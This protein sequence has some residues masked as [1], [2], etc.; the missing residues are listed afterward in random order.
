[1]E[2][3]AVAIGSSISTTGQMLVRCNKPYV[4]KVDDV[5]WSPISHQGDADV[6]VLTTS[7]L[8]E[9][10]VDDER[11]FFFRN[12]ITP[13]F[14][15]R[16]VLARYYQGEEM[17]EETRL[18]SPYVQSQFPS[19]EVDQVVLRVQL[20]TG[21]SLTGLEVIT[22][23]GNGVITEGSSEW[24]TVTISNVSSTEYLQVSVGGTLLA[25]ILPFEG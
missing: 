8:V 11:V 17:L 10:V 23:Q 2:G 6:F 19:S 12:E 1:M 3:Q 4:L 7:G 24:P 22:N 16:Y 20:R 21:D 5:V 9:I 13:I 15:P 14:R 25:F 18:Q